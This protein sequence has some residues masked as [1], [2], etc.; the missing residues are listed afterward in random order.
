MITFFK[1]LFNSRYYE[2]KIVLATLAVLIM[3]PVMSVVVIASSGL[4]LVSEALAAVNP[5][6]RLVEIF[7][8]NGN[9][10]NEIELSTA[11]PSRGYVSDEFGT[12]GE[13]RQHLKLGPHTGID[14]ANEYGLI[15]EPVTPFY[16]GKVTKVVKIDDNSCGRSVLI[17]HAYNIRSI[18][19]HLALATAVEQTNVK[20]GDIIGLMGSSG[21]STGAHL[22]F[23]AYVYDIPVNPRIF[24][25]G[26]PE[27]STV[28]SVLDVAF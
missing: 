24:I 25:V 18:Y 9:K 19:C 12:H 2:I 23:A 16:E 4:A 26:E 5:I 8:P 17:E 11:W 22:H 1:W 13:F 10:I 27:R 20:P 6:T 21:T 14:I 7:D 3:L 28:N 15:G